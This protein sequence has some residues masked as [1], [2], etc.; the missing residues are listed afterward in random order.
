MFFKV[1]T[2]VSPAKTTTSQKQTYHLCNNVSRSVTSMEI[3]FKCRRKAPLAWHLLYTNNHCSACDVILG[4]N[5]HLFPATNRYQLYLL[6][7]TIFDI[8]REV[9]LAHCTEDDN[10]NILRR[11]LVRAGVAITTAADTPFVVNPV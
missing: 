4:E 3:K 5:A 2:S 1:Q 8:L 7:H 6:F 10:A 9:K 11:N